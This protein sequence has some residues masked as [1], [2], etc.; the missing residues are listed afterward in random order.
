M[1]YEAAKVY[2]PN[3]RW[4]SVVINTTCIENGVKGFEKLNLKEVNLKDDLK[5]GSFF[6]DG[7]QNRDWQK[8][9]KYVNDPAYT[10]AGPDT[11][12]ESWR[13]S[14][15]VIDGMIHEQNEQKISST[16]WLWLND[17]NTVDVNKGYMRNILIVY[18][19]T[20]PDIEM[21]ADR[22]KALLP[23]SP[24]GSSQGL[25]DAIAVPA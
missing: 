11:D 22:Q 6:I 5:S 3:D 21:P 2:V 19:L 1:D 4:C 25:V 15:A 24:L 10:G 9:V 20:L 13:H 12:P 14:I 18:R 23:A 16:R 17:D 8:Q 7:I